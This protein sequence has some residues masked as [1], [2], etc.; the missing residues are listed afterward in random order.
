[1]KNSYFF[2][3]FIFFFLIFGKSLSLADELK[4]NSSKVNIDKKSKTVILEG[5]VSAV[6]SKNNRI[7][8]ESA[9]YNKSE[10]FIETIGKTKI[11]TSEGYEVIGS[12]IFFDNKNKV[13]SSNSSTK[14]VDK[15]GNQIFVEMF[16]YI[17]NKNMFFS[18]GKIQIKDINNNDYNFSEIYIDEKKRKIVGS[19]VKAFLN[20]ESIKINKD[21][22]PRFFANTMTLT[23]EKNEINKGVFTYCKNRDEDKCP[24]WV[25]QSKKIEHDI[26]KK[27]IYYKD[28]ILKIYDFPIF[29][30]PVFNHPD[31]TV[32]RRS[33]VLMPSFTDNKNLGPGIAVP[34]YWSIAKDRDLT[35]TP[36]LY[37]SENP[38]LMLEYRQDFKNS[39]LIIDA[40]HTPGYKKTTAKKSAGSKSHFFSRFEMNLIDEEDKSSNLEI[41]LQ[42]VTNDT[43][44]KVYEIQTALADKNV[45]VLENAL[46]Y[47]YQKEDLFFGATFSAFDNLTKQDRSKY[48]YLLPY[49]TFEKNLS[50]NEKYGIFDLSSNLRVRNYDVNKQTEFF[51]ND[52]NWKS[53]KWMAGNFFTNQFKG[54]LKTVNYN[55]KNTSEYKVDD[56]SSELSSAFGYFAKLDLYKNDLVKRNSHFLT[57]KLL[58]RYAPGHM[59]NVEKEKNLNYSNLFHINKIDE[60]DVIES[61]L[62]TSLGVEY[63]KTKLNKDGTP[64]NEL[65]SFGIGQVISDQENEDMPSSSSLDQRFSDVVGE[66][67]FYLDNNKGTFSYNFAIDQNYEDLNFNEIDG[68]LVFG[69]TKFN[70]SYLEKKD[71]KGNEESIKSGI[72]ISVNDS[73]KLS[74]STKRNLLTNSAEFYNLSYEYINDCLKAGIVFRREFYTDRDIEPDDSIMFKISILPF[75][76]LN[77]PTFSK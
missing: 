22:E 3:F 18:K 52:I 35:L 5:N 62:S 65:F 16:K 25:L 57:P 10:E 76:N 64:G 60:I 31:P 50:T 7:Y 40:G 13:I 30:F 58:L 68:N 63:K 45:N 69:N 72:D 24:P 53:N 44:L 75:G 48:E 73:G 36:K 34:Y 17:V 71:H 8:S 51:V 77:S 55:A 26:A 54:K 14:I 38:L 12:D 67:K 21:N 66:S 2:Y 42:K 28:A 61:G 19:D 32:D 11:I 33:G 43:Y 9:R 74:F 39:Y 41:K 20:Q 1:M 23:K 59:R 70:M 29:Y 46:N 6:D 15:D 4:I 47:D 37:A 56:M 49:L 27:T